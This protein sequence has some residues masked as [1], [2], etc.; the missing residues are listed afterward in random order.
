MKKKA[1]I[2]IALLM[3]I[4]MVFI[5]A[6]P[7][8]AEGNLNVYIGGKTMDNSSFDSVD[9]H[10][11]MAIELDARGRNWPISIAVN[12]VTTGMNSY[13]E[14]EWNGVYNDYYDVRGESQEF[15]IGIKKVWDSGK[16]RPFIGG[17]FAKIDADVKHT[18]WWTGDTVIR[19]S[20]SGSGYWL[21][22]G[23]FWAM[24]RFNIGFE[25]RVSSAEVE[26]KGSDLAGPISTP[27]VNV[28]GSHFGI[29]VGYN[30]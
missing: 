4:V 8:H 23:G 29:L 1:C 15:N 17:G 3:L 13:D 10:V 6:E 5:G 19:E 14:Y 2:G 18:D 12:L 20:G 22:A 9:E 11:E 25:F 26:M 16:F 30:W 27:D 21:S 24:R 28:G 7:C